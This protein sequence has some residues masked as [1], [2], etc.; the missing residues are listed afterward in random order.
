MKGPACSGPFLWRKLSQTHPHRM[1]PGSI[2]QLISVACN[3]TAKRCN[4]ETAKRCS[5]ETAK[6]CTLATY[7][8]NVACNE[9]TKRCIA[10]KQQNVTWKALQQKRCMQRFKP[11]S[12]AAKTLQ[13]TERQNVAH[14]LGHDFG[15]KWP[16]VTNGEGFGQS[17]VLLSMQKRYILGARYRQQ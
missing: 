13:A 3:D 9:T 17:R 2:R 11:K 7:Q 15:P 6:R 8:R 16:R 1:A 10:T 14:S 12:V 4:Y 5:N